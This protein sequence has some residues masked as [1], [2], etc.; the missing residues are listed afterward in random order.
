[1]PE[2][3]FRF[4]SA[5]LV[6]IMSVSIGCIE[7]SASGADS[8][9]GNAM[10]NMTDSSS[11]AGSNMGTDAGVDPEGD[12]A[13]QS[14]TPPSDRDALP[15]PP[16]EADMGPNDQGPE[17]SPCNLF[18]E[19]VDNCLLGDCPGLSAVLLQTFAADGAVISMPRLCKHML[20]RSV[21]TS[22]MPSTRAMMSSLPFA[23]TNQF[24]MSAK[25]FAKRPTDAVL[26]RRDAGR[27]AG[28]FPK[29]RGSACWALMG[30]R[31][32]SHVLTEG[33]MIDAPTQRIS[34]NR[35]VTGGHNASSMNAPRAPS[36]RV[37]SVNVSKIV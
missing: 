19:Q 26:N 14:D 35:T 3:N 34:V 30:V 28:T 27:S 29:A 4:Q 24:R 20:K 2:Q 31:N 5:M 11:E 32:S 8:D 6:L 12:A 22:W 36:P 1:M 17:Q 18:C 13:R 37:I 7:K 9:D 21:A 25:R 33:G 15:P 10:R 16:T 23:A